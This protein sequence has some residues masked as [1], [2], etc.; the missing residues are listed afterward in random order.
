MRAALAGVGVRTLLEEATA[1]LPSLTRP[2]N[3]P[4]LVLGAILG[5]AVRAG[6]RAAVLGGRP[7]ALPGIAGWV[8]ALL[9]ETTGGLLTPVVQTGGMPIVPADDLFLVAFGGRPHQDDATVAGPLA[10]QLVVWEYAAAVACYLLDADPLVP[11]EPPGPDDAG[12]RDRRAAV[13]RRRP[14]PGRGGA[15][16]RPRAR[17]RVRAGG[18]A[19]RAGPRG[20]RGRA[21]RARRLPGSRRGG[22][23]PGR[24]GA[25]AGRAPRGP[26][27]PPGHG[28][29]GRP[30]ARARE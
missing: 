28:G 11:G 10:A 15:H 25:P 14:G 9:E 24:A 8:A 16:D 29:L 26:L 21:P 18:A 4:G 23:R 1:V 20:R 3:N 13:R 7:E 6:R 22:R 5:G 30:A 12:R 19:G 27:R 17:R 2:E